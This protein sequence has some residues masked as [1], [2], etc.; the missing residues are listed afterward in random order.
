M[1]AYKISFTI[2]HKKEVHEWVRFAENQEQAEMNAKRT[3][4]D[5]FTKYNLIS[6]EPTEVEYV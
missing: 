5:T 6:V 3:L 4:D 2:G 1:K